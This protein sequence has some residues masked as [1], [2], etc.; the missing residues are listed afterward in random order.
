MIRVLTLGSFLWLA[1]CGMPA[2]VKCTAANCSGCCTEAGEC[3]G[4]SK[5]SPQSCGGMG[6]VCRVCL[7][8][9]LCV[10]GACL[11]D[12]DAGLVLDDAGDATKDLVTGGMPMTIVD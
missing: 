8:Q 5:Q 3:L 2:G 4:A 7:P 12:P 6:G 10:A 1:S 9:Q 11:R